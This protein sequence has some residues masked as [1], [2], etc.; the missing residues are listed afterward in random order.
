M[1]AIDK[2]I[3]PN[4]IIEK[5]LKY[6]INI[7]L[8]AN[9]AVNDVIIYF[10]NNEKEKYHIICKYRDLN[11]KIIIPN[12]YPFEKPIILI[13]NI[14]IDINW[15]ALHRINTVISNIINN[16]N[17]KYINQNII[18]PKTGGFFQ[19]GTKR[20]FNSMD[21]HDNGYLYDCRNFDRNKYQFGSGFI[22]SI[23][24]QYF[25]DYFFPISKDMM[26][27]FIDRLIEYPLIKEIGCVY[28]VLKIYEEQILLPI[29]NY[30]ETINKYLKSNDIKKQFNDFIIMFKKNNRVIMYELVERLDYLNHILTIYINIWLYTNFTFN[31]GEIQ[32]DN[33]SYEI[34]ELID[35]FLQTENK[36]ELYN[37]SM[38]IIGKDKKIDEYNGHLFLDNY[39]YIENNLRNSPPILVNF[40]RDFLTSINQYDNFDNDLFDQTNKIDN[41]MGERHRISKYIETNPK[42]TNFPKSLIYIETSEIRLCNKISTILRQHPLSIVSNN[43]CDNILN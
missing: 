13:N 40:F 3:D 1:D 4:T 27:M 21:L 37:W 26:N 19:D 5:R 8:I 39:N 38:V 10:I 22:Y 33:I 2:A 14:N 29:Q 23:L 28:L 36:T 32:F 15:D 16:I 24:N 43:F 41:S 34:N 17:D 11:L 25:T 31:N 20:S 6:E 9:P 42:A 35:S 30:F 7:E 18:I 12:K